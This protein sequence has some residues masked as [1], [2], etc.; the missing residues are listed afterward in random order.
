MILNNSKKLKLGMKR[1]IGFG[2]QEVIDAA[3]F[4]IENSSSIDKLEQACKLLITKVITMD[5]KSKKVKFS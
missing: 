4:T 1:E 2:V 5:K 3:D